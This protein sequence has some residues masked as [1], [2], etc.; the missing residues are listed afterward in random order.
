M[1]PD[2]RDVVA[3]RSVLLELRQERA[4]VA[5][6]REFLDRKRLLIAGEALRCLAELEQVRGRLLDRAERART[7]LI[8]AVA[9]HGLEELLAYPVSPARFRL[10]I[11]ERR[12][13]GTTLREA[14][15]ALLSEQPRP[16][17]IHPSP[18]VA[19][20]R[21]E[22]RE[23]LLTTARLAALTQNLERL[24]AQYRR[25]QRRVRALEKVVLPELEQ[26]IAQLDDRLEAQDLE[27]ALRARLA[28]RRGEGRRDGP[29]TGG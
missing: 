14:E 3:T 9:R 7:A 11:G 4:F 16:E 13:L 12:F 15:L 23:L 19:R 10:E 28:G 29:P 22:F 1:M 27:E 25:T 5:D 2:V 6:G 17:P 24:I 20:C 18:E 21:R 26:T 8:A